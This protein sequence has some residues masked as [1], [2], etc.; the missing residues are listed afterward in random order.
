MELFEIGVQ[1]PGMQNLG[2][3]KTQPLRVQN[4]KSTGV[5]AY[6]TYGKKGGDHCECKT[7]YDALSSQNLLR[8]F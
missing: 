7:S 4:F 6:G 2:G 8:K 1:A 3:K 5:V